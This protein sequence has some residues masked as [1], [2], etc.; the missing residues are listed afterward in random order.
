[1]QFDPKPSEYPVIGSFHLAS[2]FLQ[3]LQG[4]KVRS[5]AKSIP[6]FIEVS[7]KI[8]LKFLDALVINPSRACILLN[9]LVC[10]PYKRFWNFILP[11]HLRRILPSGCSSKLTEI[12][13]PLCSS[14]FRYPRRY[15]E[16][17]RL[18]PTHRY[19]R[20]HGVTTCSFPLAL[21]V[22]ILTFHL[23]ASCEL[24]PPKRRTPHSQKLG[25]LLCSFMRPIQ[26]HF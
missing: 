2:V 26:A 25:H 16:R 6:D 19:F 14:I 17:V 3:L 8:L 22:K 7:F 9:L 20:T 11:C 10:L 15:Y 18:L 5:G 23:P 4:R 13:P 24:M 1:M 12:V 21:W